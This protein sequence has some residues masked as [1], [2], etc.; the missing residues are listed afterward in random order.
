MCTSQHAAVGLRNWSALGAANGNYASWYLGFARTEMVIGYNSNSKFA[1]DF[2][3]AGNG[4]KP[5]YQVLEEPGLRLG[6]TDPL[7]DPKGCTGYLDHPFSRVAQRDS[8]QASN[9][10]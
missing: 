5:W 6:R 3:A 7:L 10:A 8:Q 1:A 2:Q 9:I 4:T